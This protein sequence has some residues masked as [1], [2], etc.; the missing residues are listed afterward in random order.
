M[1]SLEATRWTAIVG[2]QQWLW[3]RLDLILEEQSQIVKESDDEDDVEVTETAKRLATQ[4]QNI[5]PDLFD[6]SAGP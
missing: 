3:T 4:P 1:K 6:E 5:L 2:G